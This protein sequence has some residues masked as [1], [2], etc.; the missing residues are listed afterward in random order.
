MYIF[1][2]AK[3][4]SYKD[5]TDMQAVFLYILLVLAELLLLS[6]LLLS[7]SKSAIMIS[8]HDQELDTKPH[9]QC[10]VSLTLCPNYPNLPEYRNT[11]TRSKHNVFFTSR[12]NV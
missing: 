7:S 8:N 12:L 2:Y 9:T 10:C 4:I 3:N 6:L 5:S 11:H 1:M